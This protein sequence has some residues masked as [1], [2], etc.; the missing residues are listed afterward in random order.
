MGAY[1][2]CVGFTGE[3]LSDDRKQLVRET[4]A[5]YEAPSGYTMYGARIRRTVCEL[6]IRDGIQDRG[7]LVRLLLY[8]GAVRM[9]DWLPNSP[10]ANQRWPQN[11]SSYA[12]RSVG[13]G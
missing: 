8:L 13:R 12:T 5:A 3:G 6:Q 7:M 1:Y 10:E 2:V 4:Y 11:C 9:F